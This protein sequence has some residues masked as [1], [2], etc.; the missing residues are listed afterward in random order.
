MKMSIKTFGLLILI[1]SLFGCAHFD[2]NAYRPPGVI[3]A[4]LPPTGTFVGTIKRGH[5]VKGWGMTFNTKY[6]IANQ[7]GAEYIFFLRQDSKII[8]PDGTITHVS[9]IGKGVK[10]DIKIGKRVQIEYAPITDNTGGIPG[11]SG[12]DFEIGNN[13]ILSIRGLNDN[14]SGTVSSPASAQVNDSTTKVTNIRQPQRSEKS[15]AISPETLIGQWLQ[16]VN[17]DYGSGNSTL[18]ITSVSNGVLTM[19]TDFGNCAPGRIDGRLISIT[20]T[21][22]FIFTNNI[23]MQGTVV[24]DNRI[25]GTYTQTSR[26]GQCKW[27]AVKGG[28]TH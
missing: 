24:S 6:Y 1:L 4:Q 26:S 7:E 2:E 27:V 18:I 17:C 14:E 28:V 20:C 9:E 3:A 19:K 8:L 10:S 12:F 25:E 22:Q 5:G 13:R 11:A 21:K 23:V 15:G 16:T